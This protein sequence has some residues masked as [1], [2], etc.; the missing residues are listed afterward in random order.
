MALKESNSGDHT[1]DL[2]DRLIPAAGVVSAV[3]MG[4]L[5]FLG[6]GETR[7][8][9]ADKDTTA[10]ISASASVPGQGTLSDDRN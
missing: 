2:L 7:T 5:V 8:I 4:A 3:L 6:A 10:S 1:D 9:T